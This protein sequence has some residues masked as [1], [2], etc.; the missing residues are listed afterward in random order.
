MERYLL[1]REGVVWYWKKYLDRSINSQHSYTDRLL[2][3]NVPVH[4]LTYDDMTHSFL[5]MSGTIDRA[6]DAHRD[7]AT[8]LN[9]L[10]E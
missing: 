5:T 6:V 2:N 10:V 4:H 1:T 7:I 9:G 3:A 8:V